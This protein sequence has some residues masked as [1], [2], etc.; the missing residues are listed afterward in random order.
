MPDLVTLEAIRDAARRIGGVVRRTPVLD[1]SQAPESPLWLK[2]ENLQL[3]GAFKIRGALN[4]I[5]R[6]DPATSRRGVITYSSGNHGR[7]VA[8]AAKLAGIPATVVMP[9]TAP[10]IK[11]GAV[12]DLGAEVILE[13]TTSADRKQRADQEAQARGLIIV[14]PFDHEWIIAGQGTIALEIVEQCP[15]LSQVYVPVGGGGLISGIAAGVKQLKKGIRVIGVEPEGAAKMSV[16]LSAGHPVTLPKSTSIADG[17]LPVRPG[18]L[19]FVH[20]REFVDEVLTV[21]DSSI[22]TA[23]GWLFREGKLVVEPSGATAFAAAIA[24]RE[25]GESQGATVAILSGGNIAASDLAA[26]VDGGFANP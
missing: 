19:T 16:S 24:G 5:G 15:N 3:A 22:A 10:P 9:V 23:V 21:T 20:V 25:K 7:A 13:G 12:K 1:V 6:L 14:P 17:L 11:V 26:L 4:M 18:D 2:C 8:L